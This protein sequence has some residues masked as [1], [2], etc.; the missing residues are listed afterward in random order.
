MQEFTQIQCKD[1][2]KQS[3][4]HHLWPSRSVWWCL[5]LQWRRPPP[6]FPLFFGRVWGCQQRTFGPTLNNAWLQIISRYSLH[7]LPLSCVTDMPGLPESL[8]WGPM[9]H[10]VLLPVRWHDQYF[11]K[12]RPRYHRWPGPEKDTHPQARLYSGQTWVLLT[13][14]LSYWSHCER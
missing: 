1:I 3:L 8:R 12:A 13:C 4:C 6:V 7:I 14:R 11:W 9:F 5:D 2:Q 10:T